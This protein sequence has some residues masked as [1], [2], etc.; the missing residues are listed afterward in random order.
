M[1]FSNK[2]RVGYVAVAIA[3]GSLGGSARSAELPG[4]SFYRPLPSAES[5][6]AQALKSDRLSL[7][8]KKLAAVYAASG[9]KTLAS[10]FD[11]TQTGGS[12][13][14]SICVEPNFDD[15]RSV[16][17]ELSRIDVDSDPLAAL[18]LARSAISQNRESC[19]VNLWWAN[20]AITSAVWG[21]HLE[22]DELERAFRTLVSGAVAGHTAAGLVDPADALIRAMLFLERRN[23]PDLAMRVAELAEDFA[24]RSDPEIREVRVKYLQ[25]AK[26]R[27]KQR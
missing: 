13:E 5:L 22:D 17:A 14:E 19:L 6:F 1:I 21:A 20:V 15:R 2:I 11:P 25:D 16:L 9:Y 7:D 27:L 18:E 3:L 4:R 10:V 24:L 26:R 23:Q 12:K 8:R